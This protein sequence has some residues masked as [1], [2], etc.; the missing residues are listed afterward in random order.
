MHQDHVLGSSTWKK[1]IYYLARYGGVHQALVSRA[2]RLE[3]SVC[4]LSLDSEQFD[5]N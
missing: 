2:S 5:N 3:R 1:S 4:S